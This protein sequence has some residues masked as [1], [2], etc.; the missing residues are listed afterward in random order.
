MCLSRN[1]SSLL[2]CKTTSHSF[3]G[4]FFN[5][6]GNFQENPE[7]QITLKPRQSRTVGSHIHFS[8]VR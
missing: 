5:D 4:D 6:P 3:P 7:K 8:I 1:L 2:S